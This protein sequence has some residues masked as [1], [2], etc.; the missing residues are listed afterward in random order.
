M[1]YALN[2]AEWVGHD[3][4]RGQL[5][6]VG[7]VI[8]GGRSTRPDLPFLIVEGEGDLDLYAHDNVATYADGQPMP[9]LRDPADQAAADRLV[10]WPSRRCGPRASR[11]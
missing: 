3:W 11:C 2:A 6:L 10:R 9:P 1:H 8:K 5:A 4:Q 7:N